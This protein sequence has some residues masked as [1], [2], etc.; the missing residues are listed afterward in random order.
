MEK[1]KEIKKEKSK[2]IKSF[3]SY[4]EKGKNY[5]KFFESQISWKEKINSKT[6]KLKK[7]INNTKY[8]INEIKEL[9]LNINIIK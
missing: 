5:N 3:L 2:L 7:M 6:K 8:D 9:L 4:R 1:E